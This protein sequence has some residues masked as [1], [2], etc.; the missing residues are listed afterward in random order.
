MTGRPSV[1]TE[2]LADE[3]CGRLSDGESLRRICE[4]AGMPNRRT[5]LRWLEA[6][7]AFASKYAR[8]RESQADLMDDLIL[9]VAECCTPETAAADR[10]K[11]GAYQWRAAKLAPKKYGDKVDVQHSGQVD[12]VVMWG[13][14]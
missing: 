12:T 13:G 5:V 14:K 10:V 1:F 8:A 11:I 2:A 3:I 4:D 7:E 9:D 6:D